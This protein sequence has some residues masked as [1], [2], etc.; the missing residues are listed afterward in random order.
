MDDDYLPLA[1]YGVIGDG[2][3]A[4]L[5]GRHGSIDW[6]CLRRFD[7]PPTF[8]ALLDRARGGSWRVAPDEPRAKSSQAYRTDTAVLETTHEAGAGSVRVVDAMLPGGG[9]LLRV[10]EGL[11]GS[12][13]L[14]SSFEPTVEYGREPARVEPGNGSLHA[15]GLTLLGQDEPVTT[16]TL[17]PGERRALVLAWDAEPPR[18]SAAPAVLDEITAWWRRWSEGCGYVGPYREHVVRAAITLKLLTYSPTGA[19]VAAPTTSLPERIGGEANWDYRYTWLRDASI[20]IYAW[21]ALGRRE[22]GDAFFDWICARTGE[23]GDVEVMYDVEGGSNLDERELHWLEGYRGS[24][25]VRV[26]NAAFRQ[27]QLDVYGEVMECY[28]SLCAWGRHDKLALWPRFRALADRV[29]AEWQKPDSGLWES[30]APERHYVH[31]KVM[32]WVA[33]DRALR[34]AHANGL[35]G[36]LAEWAAVRDAIREWV[37]RHGW[38]E[39]LQSFRQT[40]RHD[41]V[42][43]S[44]LLLP[45]VGFLDAQDP[46]VLSTI[47]RV[48]SDL[49]VDGLLY[50]YRAREGAFT[51][52]SFWLVSALAAAGRVEEAAANYERL[53][54]RS[55][56]LGL[57]SEEVDPATGALLGNVPQAFAHAASI[58]AAINIAR[59]GDDLGVARASLDAPPGTAHLVPVAAQAPC[60]MTA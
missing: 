42:D 10:C 47:D 35:D 19:V 58:T 50:R 39:R 56:P 53:T 31:S 43:A 12:A 24:R 13:V 28:A 38:S 34:T 22:E 15:D 4:A 32:A 60:R 57:Y 17:E 27:T 46:R 36:P 9:V 2:L 40:A 6:A 51:I 49:A 7:A 59:A 33:V 26:G 5:S 37:L 44:I 20:T 11:S 48:Q 54:S 29:C 16:F 14:R 8:A 18:P 23:E 1:D 25:P 3:G 52:C 55:S 45:L 30:R 41:E 21:Y